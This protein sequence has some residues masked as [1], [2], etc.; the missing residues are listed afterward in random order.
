MLEFPLV[1]DPN[2]TN[3]Y[4]VKIIENKSENGNYKM[5]VDSGA[6]IPVWVDGLETFLFY[7]PEASQMDKKAYVG[8]FGGPGEYVDVYTIPIFSFSDGT[9]SLHYLDLPV[10]VTDRDYSFQMIASFTMLNKLNYSYLSF[11]SD[12]EEG[13]QCPVF[14]LFFKKNEYRS[15][16]L[17]T[18]LKDKDGHDHKLVNGLNVFTQ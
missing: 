7:F 2:N 5:L 15:M 6:S 13:F 18:V 10:A 14:R 11:D 16:P 1:S 17:F 3:L 4:N 12:A 8:G 9:E